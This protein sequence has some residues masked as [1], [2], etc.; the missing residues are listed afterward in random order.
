MENLYMH[1]FSL[2]ITKKEE[3]GMVEIEYE[4]QLST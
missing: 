4:W 3:G 1:W 2:A